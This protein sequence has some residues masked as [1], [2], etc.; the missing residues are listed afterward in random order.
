MMTRTERKQVT[1]V[2]D[3]T[4]IVEQSEMMQ[5]NTSNKINV[6]VQTIA[7]SRL[8]YDSVKLNP[9]QPLIVNSTPPILRLCIALFAVAEGWLLLDIG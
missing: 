3:I 4:I 2:S 1:G 7:L 5:E 9:T 6:R 8:I